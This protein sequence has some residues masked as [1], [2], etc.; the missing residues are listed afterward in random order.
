MTTFK[1]PFVQYFSSKL[2]TVTLLGPKIEETWEKRNKI[3]PHFF[4]LPNFEI[5]PS[6]CSNDTRQ[7]DFCCPKERCWHSFD[8]AQPLPKYPLKLVANSITFSLSLFSLH[9]RKKLAWIQLKSENC[10]VLASKRRG[11]E[12]G[13][14][15]EIETFLLLSIPFK[16]NDGFILFFFFSFSF[17]LIVLA[18]HMWLLAVAHMISANLVCEERKRSLLFHSSPR[19]KKVGLFLQ[20]SLHPR[21]KNKYP[22][23]KKGGTKATWF[24]AHWTFSFLSTFS[25]TSAS[26][27]LV[28]SF[29]PLPLLK[30]VAECCWFVPHTQRKPV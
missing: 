22:K 2:A 6:I 28:G 19:T 27:N 5:S 8:P 13:L 12:A 30:Q 21:P 1:K 4:A 26:L 10:L 9:W 14:Q 16:V 24:A 17:L 15:F 29:Q 3:D 18:P 7:R 25:L 23:A 20:I 11:I